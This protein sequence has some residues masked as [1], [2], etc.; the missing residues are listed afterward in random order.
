LSE[1]MNVVRC[2]FCEQPELDTVSFL[3]LVLCRECFELLCRTK[4]EDAWYPAYV[5]RIKEAWR[6]R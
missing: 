3:D 2:S 1:V 4:V 5:R 6:G